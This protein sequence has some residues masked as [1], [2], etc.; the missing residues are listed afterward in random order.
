MP[1]V[2]QVAYLSL[3]TDTA[4]QVNCL[5]LKGKIYK[6]QKKIQEAEAILKKQL[7]LMDTWSVSKNLVMYAD[8]YKNLAEICIDL[9]KYKEVTQYF[10]HP[11]LGLRLIEICKVLLNL[12]TDDAYSIFGSPDCMKLK[13]SVT[14]FSQVTHAD[15]VF[16]SVLNKFFDGRYDE[17]TLSLLQII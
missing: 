1:L 11:V 2:E 6:K 4:M 10:E 8:L 5:W 16:I 9:N 7:Q 17:K 14:L 12:E 3:P 13:S 15:P